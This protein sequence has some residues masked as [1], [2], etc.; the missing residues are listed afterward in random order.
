M[1]ALLF[2]YTLPKRKDKKSLKKTLSSSA[3]VSGFSSLGH[4]HS[5]N[6]F[7]EGDVCKL[8]GYENTLL[9]YKTRH[10]RLFR[11]YPDH[12]DVLMFGEFTSIYV[13]LICCSVSNGVVNLF[14]RSSCV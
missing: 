5:G 9:A 12:I 6:V 2:L 1:Q 7:V 11:A 13:A 10:G 8:G 3:K 4:V 14:V